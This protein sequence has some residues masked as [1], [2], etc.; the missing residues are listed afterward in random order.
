M[1]TPSQTEEFHIGI[2]VQEGIGKY[3]L[4]KMVTFTPRFILSN[5]MD[6]SVRYREP[7]SRA[8]QEVAPHSR[9]PLYRIRKSQE[10]QL[11]VKLPGIDNVWSAPFNIQDIGK[12]HVRL[13]STDGSTTMLLRVDTILEDA[14][15]YIVLS[16]ESDSEWPYLFVNRTNEDMSFYQEVR[17]YYSF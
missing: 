12:I 16:K 14:T 3:K 1:P 11:C 6:V 15:I 7:E 13:N 10:K 4:T 9:K 5:H 8:D 2:N 17:K